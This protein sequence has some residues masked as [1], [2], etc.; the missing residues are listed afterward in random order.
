MTA[1][2]HRQRL[3]TAAEDAE[4]RRL[5]DTMPASAAAAA[6]SRSKASI[7]NR[8]K[9]LGITKGHNSGGFPP[10]NVPWNKGAHF[11][12][13]GRSAETR[14]RK[15][16]L[17]CRALLLKQPVGALRIN[18]DGYL[19]R[20]INDDLPFIRRWRAEHLVLWE[21]VNGPLPAGHAVVFRDG[22]K[23]NIALEN[24]EC[25]TCAELMRR[26][27]HHNHGPE[28]AALV[29]LRGALSR[30]INRRTGNQE[31]TP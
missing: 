1:K 26:N 23:T 27:S 28:I 6:L 5:Y 29:Q 20:K 4:L 17:S 13:G 24:L 12:A 30:Q 25:I 7:K 11:I 22:D 8:V 9:K 31:S 15:G 21:A 3:W 2:N 10:G 18:V 14:F 16:H 19:E